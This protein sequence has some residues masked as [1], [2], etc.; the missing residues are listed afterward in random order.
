[1]NPH[2]TR[3]VIRDLITAFKNADVTVL[4][5][6][7]VHPCD[8]ETLAQLSVPEME[9]LI[10]EVTL[11]MSIGPFLLQARA[12]LKRCRDRQLLHE[13]A[14][15]GCSTQLFRSVFGLSL[16][17]L[18]ALRQ[19]AGVRSPGRPR[20]LT[21]SEETELYTYYKQQPCAGR[22]DHQKVMWCLA[23]YRDLGLPF[24]SIYHHLKNFGEN[25]GK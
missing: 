19:Q 20:K 16:R 13:L 24:I 17:N 23:A 2:F 18:T 21:E 3:L 11:E 6:C 8:V 12:E 25:H 7:G 22:G 10:R 5:T 15:A 14:V 4:S 9:N 1:M